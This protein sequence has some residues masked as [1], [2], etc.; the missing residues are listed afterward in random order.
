LR[1]ADSGIDDVIDT[2]FFGRAF[3]VLK[4]SFGFVFE[5]LMEGSAGYNRLPSTPGRH[6]LIQL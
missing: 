1:P 3:L 4:R 5:E 6:F 2:R